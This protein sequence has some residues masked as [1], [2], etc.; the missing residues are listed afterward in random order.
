[1]YTDISPR[2]IIKWSST[3]CFGADKQLRRGPRG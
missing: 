1:M 3:C 2:V